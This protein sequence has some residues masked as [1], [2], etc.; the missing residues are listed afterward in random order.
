MQS[1]AVRIGLHEMQA[2]T[3]S[4]SRPVMPAAAA[5]MTR[6]CGEIILPRTPPALL[7]AASRAGIRLVSFAAAACIAPNNALDELSDPVIATPSQPMPADR[8]AKAWPVAA[9][10]RPSVMVW[11]EQFMTNATVTISEHSAERYGDHFRPPGRGVLL[12]ER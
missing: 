8:K 5:P 3:M 1:A 10:Q 9:S 2:R 12:S 7:A 4:P 6:L 11:P